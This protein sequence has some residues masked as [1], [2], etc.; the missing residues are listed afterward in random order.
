M[1]DYNKLGIEKLVLK[2]TNYS[3]EVKRL[4]Q[5]NSEIKKKYEDIIHNLSSEKCKYF[6]TLSSQKLQINK[7]QQENSR[8]SNENMLLKTKLNAKSKLKSKLNL[9]KSGIST[10]VRKDNNSIRKE[11]LDNVC[12]SPY[13]TNSIRSHNFNEVTNNE[14]K[15]SKYNSMNKQ[16]NRSLNDNDFSLGN[17]STS[18]YFGNYV[19]TANLKATIKKMQ[20][21]NNN[22]MVSKNW[23]TTTANNFNISVKTNT[24]IDSSNNPKTPISTIN[25]NKLNVTKKIKPTTNFGYSSVRSANH[26]RINTELNTIYC[27]DETPKYKKNIKKNLKIIYD[28]KEE[29]MEKDNLDINAKNFPATTKHRKSIENLDKIKNKLLGDFYRN[30]TNDYPLLD[31]ELFDVENISKKDSEKKSH[32]TSRKNSRKDSKKRASILVNY[33]AEELKEVIIILVATVREEENFINELLDKISKCQGLTSDINSYLNN[34]DYDHKYRI[35]SQLT[36]NFDNDK[37]CNLLTQESDD[38]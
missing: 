31:D 9:D 26:S 24:T 36:Y 20:R 38:S 2:I 32:T 18:K 19:P 21:N 22:L 8:L 30:L 14:T 27:E 3:L 28:N 15:Q 25:S 37:E 1:D 4:K 35:R 5:I 33:S 11:N 7:L 29:E 6:K 16:I 23:K 10:S 13:N 17:F 12:V 34:H